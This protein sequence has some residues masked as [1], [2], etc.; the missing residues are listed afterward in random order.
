MRRI[1]LIFAL[2]IVVAYLAVCGFIYA[3]SEPMHYTRTLIV[4]TDSDTYDF[5]HAADIRQQIQ[6]ASFRYRGKSVD[7]VD[8]YRLSQLIEKNRLIR[9][10]RCYH[11]PD[12]S[13]RIDITQRHPIMRVK[14]ITEGDFFIDTDGETMPAFTTTAIRLPLVTGYATH[15]MVDDGLYEFARFLQDDRFWRTGITQ[16][17]IDNKGEVYL[18]PR[19]GNHT[20]L[21]GSFDNYEAKLD[22]LLEFY[23]K[24][25][26]RKGWNAY[27]VL[28][29]KFD[30]QVIGERTETK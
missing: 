20:I 12:S 13:L 29:L 5:V 9:H 11:T 28:N 30:G 2:A 21:L 14:S 15:S 25:M 16:I 1:F 17:W 19:V 23:K 7:S 3:P 18:V 22:R 10:A 27:S 6:K 24:V 8:T 4:V 26:P